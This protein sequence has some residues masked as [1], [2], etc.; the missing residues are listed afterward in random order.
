MSPIEPYLL[1]LELENSFKKIN[2]D[3][4]NSPI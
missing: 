4:N 2:I 1:S 3:K